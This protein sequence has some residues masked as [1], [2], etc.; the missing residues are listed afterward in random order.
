MT[1]MMNGPARKPLACAAAI[2]L[3]ATALGAAH[4]QN[5]YKCTSHGQVSYTDVP[6]PGE[7]GE[8]LHQ[9]SDTE[10][11]DQF[12]RLGQNERAQSYAHAHHL[13]DL[14]A[15]RL[16]LY[17]QQLTQRAE[18]AAAEATAAQQSAELARQQAQAEQAAS[19][20]AL[21]EQN[22]LLREQN[23]QYQAELSQPNYNPAP[24]YWNP[25]PNYWTPAPPYHQRPPGGHRGN[26]KP[27]AN[28]PIYHGCTQLAGGR[29]S[30]DVY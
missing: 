25:A 9:A 21:R 8:L 15:Q 28:A 12:L 3:A 19:N 7:Q 6:C 16:T 5:I 18:Q 24:I 26:G 14:Y 27:P 20:T 2:L 4:A 13:D 22:Q 17:Q 1:D 10:V 11:I 30:C 23:S 29:V